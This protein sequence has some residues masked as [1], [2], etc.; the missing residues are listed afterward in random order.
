MCWLFG[1]RKKRYNERPLC[2][3][4]EALLRRRGKEYTENAGKE[5]NQ[6]TAEEEISAPMVAHHG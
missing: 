2:L 3:T 6:A 4:K 5:N 1:T